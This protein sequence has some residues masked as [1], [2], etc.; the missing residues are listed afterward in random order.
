MTQELVARL[1]TEE[2]AAYL[3]EA[4]KFPFP[5]R[6]LVRSLDLKQPEQVEAL[7]ALLKSFQPSTSRNPQAAS[8]LLGEIVE[9]LARSNSPSAREPLRALVESDPTRIDLVTRS[10]AAHPTAADVPV[11][12]SALKTAKDMN[13]LNAALS[14][15]AGLDT[16]PKDAD[17][18]RLVLKAS[19]QAGPPS[20]KRLDALGVKLTGVKPP[21]PG[22]GF[23]DTLIYWDASTRKNSPTPPRS[24]L[25][26]S[27]S[28]ITPFHNS[29]PTS[30]APAWWPRAR[31]TEDAACSTAPNA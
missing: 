12:V 2:R 11:F 29:S 24:R 19:R 7:L 9:S 20:Q 25:R 22:T 31:P 1:S 3:K 10:L 27:P 4:L 30:S 18:L 17:T 26:N 16:V 14:A 21:K 15:L 8:E 28:T 13:T 5:S 6:V 23:D